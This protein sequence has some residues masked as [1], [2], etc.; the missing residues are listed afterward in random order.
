[1]FCIT[2]AS[3]G[4][5]TVGKPHSHDG[6]DLAAL[7]SYPLWTEQEQTETDTDTSE[8]TRG[9]KLAQ[10]TDPDNFKL[11]GEMTSNTRLK[12]N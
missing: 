9:S 11:R 4:Y 7:Q 2:I 12:C 3:S 5:K 6:F 8:L 10:V 1:M